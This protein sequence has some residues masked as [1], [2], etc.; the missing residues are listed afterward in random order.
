MTA[1]PKSKRPNPAPPPDAKHEPIDMQSLRSFLPP[2][3][4]VPA[5]EPVAVIDFDRR[6][7]VC[8]NPVVNRCEVCGHEA[9]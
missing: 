5:L 6:C 4:P 1:K 7:T 8:G 3:P 9:P 2:R